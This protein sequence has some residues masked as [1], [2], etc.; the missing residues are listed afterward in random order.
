MWSG[1]A[2]P[3]GSHAEQR[4]QPRPEW[5]ELTEGRAECRATRRKG[6]AAAWPALPAEHGLPREESQALNVKASSRR[7]TGS[8]TWG[9]RGEKQPSVLWTQD[10]S[11]LSGSGS[12]RDRG[13]GQ[14]GR[15]GGTWQE[16][17]EPSST[18]SPKGAPAYKPLGP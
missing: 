15:A 9:P 5:S 6:A 7:R 4:A 2:H 10:S 12:R 13:P 8:S 16:A 1:A 17:R 14:R 11:G 18:D 3:G